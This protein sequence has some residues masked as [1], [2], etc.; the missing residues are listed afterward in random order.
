[1]AVVEV[2]VRGRTAVVEEDADVEVAAEETGIEQ[3]R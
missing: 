2:S 3:H 1:V